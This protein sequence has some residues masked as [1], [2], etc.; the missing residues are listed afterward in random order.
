MAETS[1]SSGR[2]VLDGMGG[3]RL[4][5]VDKV[6]LVY[7]SVTALLMVAANQKIEGYGWWLGL[8]ALAAAF[9][10]L[11]ARG[12]KSWAGWI[13]HYWYPLLYVPACYKEMRVLI[14]ALWSH[15]LDATLARMDFA[16]WRVNPTV[17]LERVHHPL[18]TEV[19]QIVY[20]LFGPAIIVIGF[21]FFIFRPLAEY[22]HF[23][24]LIVLGFLLSYIGYLLVPARGPRFELRELHHVELQG[25]WLFQ[26][27]RDNLDA[28][29]GPHRDCFPSGHTALTI[30]AWWCCR[31]L[32][33]WFF[34][35][36]TI[37][38]LAQIFSTVYLRYHY[39]VDVMAGVVLA[40]AVLIGGPYLYAFLKRRD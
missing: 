24:F 22:R 3:R 12:D 13:L 18:L 23:V 29:E 25:R 37:F 15:D 17:W 6:M 1:K 7:L 9:I 36:F 33:G 30:I 39:T 26:S 16:I 27:L 28:L 21:L 5:P 32:W 8:H 34:Y 38:M 20:T 10:F 19:L 11:A 40:A 4:W 31:R 14:E 2:E 35:G